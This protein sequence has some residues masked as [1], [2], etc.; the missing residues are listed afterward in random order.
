M[1]KDTASSIGIIG[2]PN[3]ETIKFIERKTGKKV[4]EIEKNGKI[5]IVIGR[6][7]F[8]KIIRID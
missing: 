3:E 4:R 7:L 1:S 5:K 2:N 8:R 6:G